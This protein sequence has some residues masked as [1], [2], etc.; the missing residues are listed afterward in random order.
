MKRFIARH[1][2][3][4]V[5]GVAV[6]VALWFMYANDRGGQENDVE[7]GRQTAEQ[8]NAEA[9]FNLAAMYAAGEGIQQDEAEAVRWYRLAAEQGHADA[10]ASLGGMY[11]EGRG[12]PQDDAEAVRWI[13]LA[14]ERGQGDAQALLGSMYYEGRGVPQDDILAYAFLHSAAPK[15]P[16]VKRDEITEL[17]DEIAGRMTKPEIDLAQLRARMR[18]FVR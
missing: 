7:A 15:F 13:R 2:L 12:V 3:G 5:A 11:L 9:Q 14:A 17:R 1:R 8:G 6:L 10:Q 16:G 4:S 18:S